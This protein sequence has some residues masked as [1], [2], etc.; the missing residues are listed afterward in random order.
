MKFLFVCFPGE[1]PPEGFPQI[2]DRLEISLDENAPRPEWKK[3]G[4]QRVYISDG[5]K[6]KK[7]KPHIVRTI[8]SLH[9]MCGD[10]RWEDGSTVFGGRNSDITK[11]LVVN[12]APT[13][14]PEC[15]TETICHD[16]GTPWC[17]RCGVVTSFYEER[18]KRESKPQTSETKTRERTEL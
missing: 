7:E 15:E 2:A 4:Y 1:E 18:K 13:I 11:E 8:R 5:V 6:S 16:G 10:L 9:F 17:T 12:Y 3:G 14:C